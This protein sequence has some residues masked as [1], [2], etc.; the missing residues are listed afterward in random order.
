MKAMKTGAFDLYGARRT[1]HDFYM[2][3]G[4]GCTVFLAMSAA[5]SWVLSR[6]SG[7]EH[8]GVLR[9]VKWILFLAHAANTVL[10]FRYFFI[11]PM[12]VSS[13]ITGLLGWECQK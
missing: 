13:V 12:L 3:F 2:G 10:C 1:L 11:P 7:E 5:L 8:E 6:F 9:P 4:L